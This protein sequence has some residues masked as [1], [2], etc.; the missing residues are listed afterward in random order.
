MC[1]CHVVNCSALPAPQVVITS[2]GDATAGEPYTLTC[3]ATVIENL[4]VQPTVEWLIGGQSVINGNGIIIEPTEV[5]G[6][7]SSRVLRIFTLRSS[8]GGQY[9][10]RARIDI[11]E[12]DLLVVNTQ[13]RD[14][15]VQCKLIY[16]LLL[17]SKLGFMPLGMQFLLSLLISKQQ[18]C[19]QFMGQALFSLVIPL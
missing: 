16:K 13:E 6:V 10:C 14:V 7:N 2:S 17:N 3:T 11:S 4:V 12:A 18:L 19:D 1:L 8:H 15:C 5:S 9:T